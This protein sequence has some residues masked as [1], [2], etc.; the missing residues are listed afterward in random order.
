MRPPEGLQLVSKRLQTGTA[1]ERRQTRYQWQ[2]QPGGWADE[3]FEIKLRNHK[4]EAATIRVVEHLY[5]WTN[6]VITQESA[7]HRQVDGRTIEY[8]VTL[9]PD[10]EKTLTYSAHYSW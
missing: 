7:T 2:M 9:K 1:G 3:A 6:W 10:E 4:Q 8:E 5:R